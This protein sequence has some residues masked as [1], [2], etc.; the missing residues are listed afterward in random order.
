MT[1]EGCCEGSDCFDGNDLE[2]CGVDGTACESC[3]PGTECAS[4]C[5]AAPGA[6]WDV[7]IIS[8]ELPPQLPSGASWDNFGGA[9]DPFVQLE[10]GDV[11]GVTSTQDNTYFPT[12]D[13]VV[14]SGLTTED[15]LGTSTYTI[16]DEDVLGSELAGT[17][18]FTLSD[19][20]FG[21][22]LAA[23]CTDEQDPDTVLWT[24]VLAVLATE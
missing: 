23:E 22:T 10:V 14:L 19:D 8:A 3:P 13:E 1:C 6:L 4:G 7:I 12:W 5:R 24:L 15:L 17:C 9:P 16:R 20:L 18:S 11:S 21:S 2:S